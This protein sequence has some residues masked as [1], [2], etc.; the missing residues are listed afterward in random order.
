MYANPCLGE[1]VKWMQDNHY[2]FWYKDKSDSAYVLGNMVSVVLLDKL[3]LFKSNLAI[4]LKPSKKRI[5]KKFER[6]IGSNG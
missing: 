1:L 4:S 2:T 3:A 6:L 5:S